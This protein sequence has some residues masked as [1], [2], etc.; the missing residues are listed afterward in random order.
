MFN[1]LNQVK[2]KLEQQFAREGVAAEVTFIS[3]RMFSVFCDEAGQF[4][5]AKQLMAA[6]NQ[7]YDSE[8]CDDELGFCAY[9]NF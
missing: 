2:A 3:A 8:N 4:V 6:A 7:A 9:Y 5:K 1:V